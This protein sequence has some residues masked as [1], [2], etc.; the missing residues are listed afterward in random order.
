MLRRT[1]LLLLILGIVMAGGPSFVMASDVRDYGERRVVEVESG[2]MAIADDC[3]WIVVGET[4]FVVGTWSHKGKREKTKF[5]DASGE[6]MSQCQFKR[7]NRVYVKGVTRKDGTLFAR[8][9]QLQN[10]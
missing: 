8:V 6:R 2:V 3:S 9:I 10:Q 5:L 7:R 4:P 1:G